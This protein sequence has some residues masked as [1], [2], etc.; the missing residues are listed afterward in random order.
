MRVSTITSID[1][2]KRYNG[3]FVRFHNNYKDDSEVYVLNQFL[4]ESSDLIWRVL[5]DEWWIPAVRDRYD[6]YDDDLNFINSNTFEFERELVDSEHFMI[7]RVH[8][9]LT[10][11]LVYEA[12]VSDETSDAKKI[13]AN[14]KMWREKYNDDMKDLL[15]TSDFYDWDGSGTITV[16]EKKK[17]LGLPFG[18]IGRSA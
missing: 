4:D 13:E 15:I 10:M 18:Y 12:F 7:R 5:E 16:W 2:F 14:A 3:L 17:G 8:A 6:I 11:A 1:E 9:E